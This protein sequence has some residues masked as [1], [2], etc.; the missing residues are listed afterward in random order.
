M[1]DKLPRILDASA[2]VELFQGHPR[3]M[4]ILQQ[5][6]LGK[7]TI[8][9]PASAVLEAQVVLKATTSVWDHVLGGRVCEL[10]L[11]GHASV[12]AGNFA[13]P[14]LENYPMHRVLTGPP[15]VGHVLHEAREM[16]G[17]IVTGVPFN[18]GGHSVPLVVLE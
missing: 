6:D 15:M 7:F 11:Q 17:A 9:T 10:P 1:M 13:R 4:T 12:E 2:L 5:A 8:S 18:Y 14:R 3:V 16:N